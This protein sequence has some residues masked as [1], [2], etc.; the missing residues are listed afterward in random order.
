MELSNCRVKSE[1]R[2][3]IDNVVQDF[4]IP[5]LENAVCYRRA[6]G[7]FSSTSL[8]E[9]SKGIAEMAKHGGKI[10]IVASPFLSEE[11]IEAIKKGYSSREDIIESALLKE[12]SDDHT[13]YYSMERLNLLA[14]LIADG[15]LDIR[16]AYTEDKNGIGMYHEKMGII[17][18]E[19]GNSVAFSGSM[20]ESSTAMS[21]NYE[22]IDVFCSWK[23]G[24]EA[25]RVKL[26]ENA[27]YSIWNDCEPNIHVMEFPSISQALIDK[28]KRSKPNFLIDK[29]QFSKRNTLRGNSTINDALVIEKAIGARIPSNIKLHPYQKDAISVWVGENYRGIFDMATG[30]GKTFTGLG[31][32]SKLS[33]DLCDDLAVVIVCPYQHLVEQWVE[34]IVK[35]N[36]NPIIGYSSSSQKDWKERLTKAIRNQKIRKD[37]RFFCFVCTNATFANQF[38]QEQLSKVKSPLLL[39]VDEAH[40]F[41]AKSYSKYLDDRF[42]YR[43]ALSATLERH[44]DEEGTAI[45]Y[46]FFGKKCIEYSLERAINEEKLTPYKYFPVLVYLNDEELEKYEQ[47]SYEISKHVIKGK[48]GKVKLDSYGEILA[49]QRSRVVAAAS[50][51]L[52]KLKE[53]IEPYIDEH[54]I[55]VYCGATNVMPPNVDSSSTDEMDI[56]QIE[57]VTR[58][59]GNDLGMKVSKFTAEEK[60][61]ERHLIKQHFKNGDDLQAIVAIKCLDEGVNIPGI[62]TAFI[63]AS[64]T[65]PKEYIQ[66]RGRVL[67]KSP[68]TGKEYAEIFDFVTLPR[69]LDEVSGLTKEQ[70]KRDVSLVK[71]ELTRVMEFGRLSMNSMEAQKLIW[72][73][74]D[75]YELPYDLAAEDEEDLY[76]VEQ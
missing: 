10:Q 24:N 47:L 46:N 71:N 40:N 54:F 4:Y 61:E 72:E 68:E 58:I 76:G 26:K 59:L 22:T 1:Y 42:T 64:T 62:K 74:C 32:I 65:N 12:L 50:L 75:C 51:K 11:D 39:V 53:V 2:S 30:T 18:D 36:I 44:R 37:K 7:F 31:A 25:E 35:F 8:V 9:I 16:I 52:L 67:R 48:G 28:Y 43:L 45:L 70:V 49:I 73:I 6:V 34:D 27:F 19:C 33:E 14:N 5:L 56:K 57:A 29:E 55:L 17:T 66:R 69:P 3:L 38:V 15:V 20:N 60:I 21:V 63:L 13:D 23:E 41:G